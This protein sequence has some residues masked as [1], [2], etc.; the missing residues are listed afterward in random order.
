ME[1]KKIKLTFIA[2]TLLI[3]LI[4]TYSII[5]YAAS[6]T[7]HGKEPVIWTDKADYSP[8]QTVV[9]YGS[10]FT[11]EATVHITLERPDGHIDQWST[12]ADNS[13]SFKTSYLLDGITGVYTIT[14]TDGANTAKTTFTD[15]KPTFGIRIDAIN[16]HPPPFP[17]LT[18]PVHLEGTAWATDFPGPIGHYQVQVDWG[19]GTVDKDSTCNFALTDLD[20]D[21]IKDDLYGT[22]SSSPDHNYAAY[23]DWIITVKLYHQQPPGAESADAET[24][25]TITVM[26]RI[27]ITTKPEGLTV[28][29][30]GAEYTAPIGFDW[31][32]G[33]THS[34]SVNPT[35]LD[36]TPGIQYVWVNWSDGGGVTHNIVV[37]PTPTTY[38]ANFKTQYYLT[39][40]SPYATANG[41][42]WYD[43]GATAYASLDMG[44]LD[45]GN[46]T[47]RVFTN[48]NGDAS[49]TDYAQSNPIVM[50]SP[51]TA[52]ATWKTQHY[53]EVSSVYGDPTPVSGWYDAGTSI[54]ATVYSPV[55]GSHG[56]RYVC[57]GWTGTGSVPDSGTE[58]TV[59]FT[60]N[61]PSSITWN[62]KTQHRLTVQTTP[63]G[64]TPQP[65]RNPGGEP[66]SANSWWY[67][68]STTVTLT[69]QTVTDYTFNYWSINGVPQGSE[70]NPITVAIDGPHTAVAHYTGIAT[71]AEVTFSVVGVNSDFAGTVL[72]VDGV[73]YALGSLP[74]TFTWEIGSEHTFTFGLHLVVSVNAKQYT[75][76]STSGLSTAQSGKITVPSEGG[77][78]AANYKIQYYLKVQS[79]YGTASGEGWY[80]ENAAAYASLN[81]GLIV[82]DGTRHVFVE[83]TA[84]AAGTN[85]AQSDPI[86]MNTAKTA[87]A[88][89][90]T[91]HYLSVNTNPAEIAALNPSATSGEGWYDSGTTATVDAVQ[92]VDKITGVSKYDFRCWTGATPTGVDNQATV[93]MDAPKTAIANYQLQWLQTFDASTNV[94]SDGTGTII[95]VN[96]VPISADLLP[97]TLWIDDGLTVTFA[98]EENVPSSI[99]GKRYVLSLVNG[100][101]SGYTVSSANTIVGIYITQFYLSVNSAYD[102]PTPTSG[103]LDSG[104]SISASVTSPWPNAPETRYVCTGWTGTGSVPPSGTE[105]SVEFTITEPSS[106]TWNWKTQYSVS[107]TQTGSAVPPA[108]TYKIDSGEIVTDMV[109]FTVWVDSGSELSYIF[110]ETLSGGAGIRYALVDF[111][112][113]SPQTVNAPLTV[114]ANY[115]VQ[116]YLD[117]ISPYGDAEGMGWYGGGAT[118]YATINHKLEEVAE[119]VRAVFTGWTGDASGTELVSNP[120]TMNAP[121]TAIANWKTQFYLALTSNPEGVALPSGEGW[122]DEDT[123]AYISTPQYIELGADSTRYRF[124]SWTTEDMSELLDP[125]AYYTQVLMDKAKTVTANYAKQYYLTVVVEPSG[126]AAIPG[127]GWYDEGTVAIIAAPPYSPVTEGLRFRFDHWT[128]D[129]A[130][131]YGN[132]LNVYMDKPHLATAHYTL[133]YGVTFSQ[134]GLDFFAVGNVLAINGSTKNV[135]EL[136]FTIWV[137]NIAT[138]NYN[139]ETLVSSSLTGERYKLESVTGPAS[140]ITITGATLVT[141]NY[142]SQ[143]QIIFSQSGV[144]LDFAGAV[145][146]VD[147]AGLGVNDLPKVYWWD[148]GSVHSY[149]YDSPLTAGAGKRYVWASI[150]G[151]SALQSGTLTIYSSGNLTGN[152]EAMYYLNVVSEY[153]YTYGSGWYQHGATAAFGVTTPVNHGNGTMRVFLKWSGDA[154]VFEPEGTITMTKPSTVTASWETRYLVTFNTALPNNVVLDIPNVPKT[155]PPGMEVFG[156]YY[157]AD[158]LVAVG[159]APTTVTESKNVRYVFKGWILNSELF[160]DEPNLSFVVKR[161]SAVAVAYDTEFLLVV[162][163]LGVKEPFKATVTIATSSPIDYELS[164]AIPVQEWIKQGA[165]VMLTISTPNK[166]GRGEWAI[167]KE[168]TGHVTANDKTVSFTMLD[169][170]VVN[171]VFFKVNPVEQSLPYSILAGLVMMLLCT[172]TVRRR[173]HEGKRKLRSATSGVTVAAVTIIVAAIISSAIAIGYGINPIELPDLTNW[174]VVFLIIEALV[175]LVVSALVAK[176]VQRTEKPEEFKI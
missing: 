80:D 110:Q 98:Y 29:V 156:M 35:Q 88:Q 96:G 142:V 92:K 85:Y 47:R 131:T 132:S 33:E 163:A 83:W 141:G 138:V 146:N 82:L 173:K 148:R 119:N 2:L 16:G 114:V 81:T 49:G 64:L 118:A 89:W 106:L 149:S 105:T 93:Y 174:A 41:E 150:T 4:A 22:W 78:V 115:M 61:E 94:K 140:P 46:G 18:S 87:V 19:G 75:W 170:Q 68:A 37:P 13:G 60:L 12:T 101:A 99:T 162:N 175:F 31:C 127:G 1:N 135:S 160:T 30:D 126:A 7:A 57:T 50:D 143:C 51:K 91:Q 104:T 117:V 168:W 107:F 157:S 134:K 53:L 14:A 69:A 45:H 62:W 63:A 54:T 6:I 43:S 28:T 59:A 137:D 74:V 21:G 171:A 20:G 70:V 161:P 169:S 159:P 153:G 172:L 23:G 133:Q 120:I 15:S 39:V 8:E 100:P 121:K 65:T 158:E 90:K 27:T 167:F 147:G 55:A 34:V 17:F 151:L 176:K 76:T 124:E 52:V 32:A 84:D 48:W 77:T 11:P 129:E 113:I 108:V 24:S 155:L 109:P 25:V 9:I 164:P 128:L 72:T 44:I 154:N 86:T 56:T 165:K 102:T 3:A 139:Y 36:P 97:Y 79:A 152:Y 26:A 73:E 71:T 95:A 40:T 125:K 103:W 166:I 122:Y 5:N 116:Y 10:D 112:P 136:P 38:T 145:V 123:Y 111:N 58:T 67:D 144:G 66:D 42:G 130:V